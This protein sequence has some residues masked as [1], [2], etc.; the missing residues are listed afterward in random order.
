MNQIKLVFRS[1]F[2]CTSISVVLSVSTLHAVAV[3]VSVYGHCFRCL[4]VDRITNC[5]SG[6]ISK[7][8]KKSLIS[9][10]H[11]LWLEVV[12]AGRPTCTVSP[13][14]MSEWAYFYFIILLKLTFKIQNQ[15]W[16]FSRHVTLLKYGR[17]GFAEIQSVYGESALT[18]DQFVAAYWNRNN[19]N[20]AWLLVQGQGGPPAPARTLQV[21][22]DVS[23]WQQAT[24]ASLTVL[25][26]HR[27]PG[28]ISVWSSQKENMSDIL[29]RWLNEELRL[30]QI[31]GE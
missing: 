17:H 19:R 3:E 7:K 12:Q 4:A 1:C 31:V 25:L 9:K 22:A 28:V 8:K 29:C 21:Q 26:S 5:P 15:D 20:S 6:I 11:R 14:S 2:C 16:W 27:G 30:S 24:Q 23:P 13:I 18:L 10:M